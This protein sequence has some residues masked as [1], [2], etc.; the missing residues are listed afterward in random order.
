MFCAVILLN[1]IVILARPQSSC[2]QS[3]CSK[4]GNRALMRCTMAAIILTSA[5]CPALMVLHQ[6]LRVQQLRET[7]MV[8]VSHLFCHL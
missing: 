6:V 5:R 8:E 2:S 7:R 1:R 3:S 4:Q